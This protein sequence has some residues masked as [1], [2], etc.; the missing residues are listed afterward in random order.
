MQ[1]RVM[2]MIAWLTRARWSWY[3]NKERFLRRNWSIDEWDNLIE[4]FLPSLERNDGN[5]RGSGGFIALRR[6]RS[7]VYN[8]RMLKLKHYCFDICWLHRLQQTI[9]RHLEIQ[10]RTISPTIQWRCRFGSWSA[11]GNGRVLWEG[12]RHLNWQVISSK[13]ICT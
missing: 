5:N 12:R 11:Q 7:H 3:V 2:V 4:L 1:A 8:R 13:K 9:A 6:R 10:E